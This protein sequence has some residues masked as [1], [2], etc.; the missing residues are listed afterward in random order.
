MDEERR[1][2]DELESTRT[3]E[4]L[5]LDPA[6]LVG[7]YRIVQKLGEGGMGEVYEAQQEKPV[8][9]RVALKL[10]KLGMDSKQVLARFESERQALAL[11]NHPCVAK[12]FDA[13]TTE[14]GRP[15][16]AME[17]V[18]GEPITTYCDRHRL[19]TRERIELFIQ[20]CEG[21]QHAHQK[22]II[23]RDL[24]PSNVLVTI[25]DD[26]PVPKIIDFGVAKAT[27][28][29][30]TEKTVF[31]HMGVLIGTPE[32]MSP[33]Q[34][35][36]TGLD[37]DTRTDVYSLGVMLYELLVGALPFD[38]KELRSA[39]YE[40]LIERIRE[41]E[42]P[43]PSR[44]LD[45]LGELS[46]QSAKRRRVDPTT[47]QRQL[48][49][50]LD[51]ITM[52]AMEKDRTRRYGSPAE[53]AADIVRHL[54]NEPVLAGP[55]S[56]AYRMKKFV[57]RHTFG[58]V[59]S[60]AGLVVLIAFALTMAILAGR[61]AAE[62]DRA[63]REAEAKGQ[64]SDFL[65]GL[66]EVSD[67]DKARG[68]SI[69]A[70]QLLDSGA[71]K[72]EATLDDQPGMRAE[73]MSTMGEV[74]QKLGIYGQAERLLVD[75]L[76]TAS[77]SLGDDH[78][79][80][81]LTRSKLAV[82]YSE[83]GRYSEAEPLF[84]RVLEVRQRRLGDSHPDSLEAL[85]HL[86]VVTM[87]QG[88]LDEAEP[89][90]IRTLEARRRALGDDDPDT[91]L[92]RNNLAGLYWQQGL[93]EKAET[94]FR[95]SLEAEQ[96]VLGGSHS[97]TLLTQ[98]NLAGVL[99]QQGRLNEA[100]TLYSRTLEMRKRVL[101]DDH[102][103]TLQSQNGL[104]MLYDNQGRYEQS[105]ELFLRTIE[106]Q[107]RVLPQDHP[108]T[109]ITQANLAN[110]YTN[111]G[112]LEEAE[113]LYRRTLE[114]QKRVLGGSHPN[115]VLSMYNLACFESLYGERSAALDWLGQ[116][117]DAGFADITLIENDSDLASLHGGEFD[118]LLARVRKNVA[119]QLAD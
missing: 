37:V 53:L 43:K 119:A 62:R 42:P 35:E 2:P 103:L 16:F 91:L 82:L 118:A 4:P 30:L 31:T 55:P 113:Q 100:E 77:D 58:V 76:E 98:N 85:H 1:P 60:A 106:A 33:E 17:Y 56:T 111:T 11:M 73:L 44:R 57:R 104:A 75:A 84:R 14:Q 67:P 87:R 65:V 112:R 94:L 28:Q 93:L 8:R 40:G 80:T 19:R 81:A 34:A 46:S 9:R 74:Y 64:V 15:F 13:G 68:D 21:V 45:S 50:D 79:E 41:T 18:K 52:R 83:Q 110:L 39:G 20:V 54:N 61:I 47:L 101:G 24:K 116:A 86:A 115:T 105:E 10:I 32:Y 59:A 109:L 23:H 97:T 36:M 99:W 69:T 29:R 96:R 72:I 71:R 6:V 88:R 117:V 108:D 12:V 78:L 49:G 38:S 95:D 63:N 25:Q 114:A 70:R 22:G 66:F 107:K 3:G 90:F 7:H 27:E 89:L 5:N 48:R 51:W 26:R 102:P 92:S